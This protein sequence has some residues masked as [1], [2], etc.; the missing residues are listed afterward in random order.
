MGFNK[1][2][3][4]WNHVRPWEAVNYF[5]FFWFYFLITNAMW[6][7][8]V[9]SEHIKFITEYTPNPH[10]IGRSIF[11]STQQF[12]DPTELDNIDWWKGYIGERNPSTG[13]IEIIY[14]SDDIGIDEFRRL[15]RRFGTTGNF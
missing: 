1:I 14:D 9:V 12:S 15:C 4:V 7:R 11:R 2:D 8:Y 6:K 5:N 13:E 3:S 10:F